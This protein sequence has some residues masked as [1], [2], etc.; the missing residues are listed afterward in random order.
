M[1]ALELEEGRGLEHRRCLQPGP[2]SELTNIFILTFST[3]WLC[4]LTKG[5]Y[6]LGC[7]SFPS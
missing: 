6:E 3:V 4:K 1:C 2:Q 7:E 5:S